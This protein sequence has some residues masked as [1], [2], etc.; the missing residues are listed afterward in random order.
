MPVRWSTLKVS[1][2]ADLIEEHVNNAS[3]PLELAREEALK[4]LEIPN[5]PQYMESEFRSL[6][7][8][9]EWAIGKIRSDISRIRRDLPKDQL[10]KEQRLKEAGETLALLTTEE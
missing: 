9:C 4:A 7:G 5:L 3:A 8:N 6:A 1:Q 2:A 10:A